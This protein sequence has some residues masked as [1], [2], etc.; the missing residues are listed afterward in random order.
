MN[1]A[2]WPEV[3]ELGEGGEGV[4]VA[5]LVQV[6]VGEHQRADVG[7]HVAQLVTHTPAII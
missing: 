6:V 2:N 5:Q 3:L 7:D 1:T 4:E